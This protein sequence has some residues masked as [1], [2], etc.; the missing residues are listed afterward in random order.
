[1]LKTNLFKN[2]RSNIGRS[3]LISMRIIPLLLVV[4]ILSGC[5]TTGGRDQQICPVGEVPNY[6]LIPDP[7]EPVNRTMRGMNHLVM[8]GVITPTSK[9]YTFILPRPVRSSIS[10]FGHNLAFPVRLTNNVLQTKFNGAWVESKRFLVNSTIGVL[11]L[12]D[13]ASNMGIGHSEEDMGQT[14]GYWGWQ[15]QLFLILPLLGPS[16]ER[17]TLGRVGDR[18]LDPATYYFP[19]GPFFAYNRLAGMVDPYNNFVATEYDVYHM[20]R[21][22]ISLERRNLTRNFPTEFAPEDEATQTLSYAIYFKSKTLAFNKQSL[23]GKVR[24][25]A[26]GKNLPF[27]YWLQPEPAPLVYLLPGLGSHRLSQGTVMMAKTL[28]DGGYSVAAIS[29]MMHPEFMKNAASNPLPGYV[30]SNTRDIRYAL[31]AIGEQLHRKHP[32]QVES[33]S[34]LGISLGGFNTLMIAAAENDLPPEEQYQRYVAINAPVNLYTGMKTLDDYFQ[35]PLQWGREERQ[36]RIANALKKFLDLEVEDLDLEVD[37]PFDAIE[38]RYLIGFNFRNKLRDVIFASQ[39]RENMGILDSSLSRLRRGPAYAEIG[40][41]S[42]VDY[43][44]KFVFPYYTER[45]E[46]LTREKL[47]RS[48]DL[49]TY[50][51]YLISNSR[52]RIINNNNDFLVTDEDVMWLKK[53]FDQERLSI[54]QNGGHM[55][56]LHKPEIQKAI[57]SALEH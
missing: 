35:S 21:I 24:I 29:S 20:M 34:L 57:L 25:E 49:R 28:Y 17:D 39:R 33:E 53:V 10:R 1:M 36:V 16:N 18:F 6:K 51:E 38:S 12:F 4:S 43:F 52:C 8:V 42:Y 19:A 41:Y 14:F 13:P 27:S 31:R 54:F 7:L 2:I 11:G 56:N 23:A 30:P 44:D 45:I 22:Y 26:T 46:N 3:R 37:L 15:P 47:Q 9:V 50:Q 5:A 40:C 48:A 55:G 32:G